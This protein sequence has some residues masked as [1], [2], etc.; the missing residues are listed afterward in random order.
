MDDNRGNR[1]RSGAL[2]GVLAL[3]VASCSATTDKIDTPFVPNAAHPAPA[4]LPDPQSWVFVGRTAYV[5]GKVLQM[6]WHKP[7]QKDPNQ[8]TESFQYEETGGAATNSWQHTVILKLRTTQQYL[9]SMKAVSQLVCPSGSFTPITV[10]DSELLMEMKSGGCPRFG[11]M[12]EIDYYRFGRGSFAWIANDVEHIVY[13]VKSPDMTPAQ[14]Q[15][16]I[17][18]V[19]SFDSSNAPP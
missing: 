13:I 12:D 6:T 18:A 14:R 19:T 15:A 11:A 1:P 3:I 17:S 10:G 16:G 2:V 8:W 5:P 4:Q 9:D 7:S